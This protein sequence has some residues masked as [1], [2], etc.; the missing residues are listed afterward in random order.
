MAD[1]LITGES[2]KTLSTWLSEWKNILPEVSSWLKLLALV[3]LVAATCIIIAML[4]TPTD[5]RNFSVYPYT[6]IGLLLVVIIGIFIDQKG[7]RTT[8]RQEVEGTLAISNVNE[9]EI[10]RKTNPVVGKNQ[11]FTDSRLEFKVYSPE[12]EGWKKAQ[13]L[14]WEEFLANIGY[15]LDNEKLDQLKQ[16]TV[17]NRPFG[18]MFIEAEIVSFQ[19][20]EAISIEFIDDSSTPE[21]EDYI[22][23][24]SDFLAHSGISPMPDENIKAMRKEIFQGTM[25]QA[26]FKFPISM[27]IHVLNKDSGLEKGIK[28]NLGNLLRS[29]L[30]FSYDPIEQISSFQNSIIWITRSKMLNVKVNGSEENFTIYRTYKLIEAKNNF[31]I[32]QIQWSPQAD[33]EIEVWSE[34]QAMLDSFELMKSPAGHPEKTIQVKNKS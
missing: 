31:Y 29:M 22:V 27:N 20:G 8:S 33:P 19:Y 5:N 11:N 6:L 28:P 25:D 1:K 12:K 24:Y 26:E 30:I 18:K 13:S 16:A 15:K 4:I 10:K 2:Q 34:L 21:I 3:V 9:I 14:K 17:L 23:N 7:Q 32:L